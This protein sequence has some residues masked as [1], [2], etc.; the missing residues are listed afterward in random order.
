MNNLIIKLMIIIILILCILYFI[1]AIETY[2]NKMD[3]CHFLPRGGSVQCIKSCYEFRKLGDTPEFTNCDEKNCNTLCKCDGN[4][5]RLDVCELTDT[6]NTEETVDRLKIA[7]ELNVDTNTNKINWSLISGNNHK[8]IIDYKIHIT[9]MY[10]DYNHIFIP[11]NKMVNF[12]LTS[13]IKDNEQYRI[14]IY[15]IT[16]GK[17]LVRSDS[18][19]YPDYTYT[20]QTSQ[21]T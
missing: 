17:N 2:T 3:S 1:N 10:N 21:S 5:K 14:T 15:G 20:P 11:V 7:I 9:Q 13:I 16:N 18:K 4:Q 19:Y 6:E 8:E 12:D